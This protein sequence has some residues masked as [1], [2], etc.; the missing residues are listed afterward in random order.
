MPKRYFDDIETGE[1]YETPGITITDWHIGQYSGLSMDY[2]ELH[3]SDEFAKQTQF[4]RRVAHGL[5]GLAL[6]D[7]L[8][9][10]SEFQV[11]AVASLKWTWEFT[12][13]IFVG[14]TLKAKLRVAEKRASRSK[15]DR[16]ILTLDLEL[17]NQRGEVVQKGQNLLLVER[18]IE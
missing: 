10:R 3:T 2:F 12:G 7:G 14:D 5:L 17:T 1:T 11:R 18:K 15:P 16:G 13:P 8:K 9:N 4:G 6:T